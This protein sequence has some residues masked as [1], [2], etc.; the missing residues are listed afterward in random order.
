MIAD[1]TYFVAEEEGQIVGCGGWSKRNALFGGDSGRSDD[2]ASL[3]EPPQD[4]ARLRAFFIHPDWARRG[5][6]RRLIEVC[7]Q[8]AA[9]A[10]FQ[11]IEL[12]GT[13][14]GEPLYAAF[15]YHVLERFE[16]VLT[17]KLALPV[18]RMGKAL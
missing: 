12:V 8:A 10:G 13:L 17:N 9:E 14:A 15:S 1:K 4:A 3:L 6:G 16:I 7:E 18:V 11:R 5:I 2:A